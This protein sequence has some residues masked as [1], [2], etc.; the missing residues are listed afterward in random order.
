[1]L[2]LPNPVAS[3]DV[4]VDVHA[5]TSTHWRHFLSEEA[6]VFLHYEKTVL[7]AGS[8]RAR[9]WSLPL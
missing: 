2:I 5:S 3:L 1:M 9:Q 7:T 8:D 4:S 6:V